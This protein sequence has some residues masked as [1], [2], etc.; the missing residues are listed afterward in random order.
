MYLIEGVKKSLKEDHGSLQMNL[1]SY[2][3]GYKNGPQFL[4]AIINPLFFVV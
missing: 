2:C 3:K 1:K 4:F